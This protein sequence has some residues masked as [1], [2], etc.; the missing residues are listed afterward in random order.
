MVSEARPQVAHTISVDQNR[1]HNGYE[2]AKPVYRS[3]KYVSSELTVRTT[4]SPILTV[5][6]RKK[7]RKMR[8]KFD[9]DMRRSNELYRMEQDANATI[10]RI[11]QFNRYAFIPA[12]SN[13]L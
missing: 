11:A 10:K 6:C 12:A 1:M 2:D 8:L 5:M 4:L 13:H 7:Y 9:D 3:Y